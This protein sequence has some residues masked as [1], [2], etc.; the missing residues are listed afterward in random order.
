MAS[1]DAQPIMDGITRI[2]LDGRLDIAGAQEID[3]RFAG[4]V[5]TVTKGAV[6]DLSGVT[7]L[8]SMGIRTLISNA[9]ALE[10][11]GASMA[12]FAPSPLVREVL[13]SVGIPDLIPVLD[14]LDAAVDTVKSARGANA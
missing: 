5:S 7:F 2:N 11:R 6:V 3:L 10:R 1:I 12:L 13:G 9:K 14:D 8:T 4:I